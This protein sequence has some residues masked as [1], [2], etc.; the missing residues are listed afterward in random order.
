MPGV[1]L[2]SSQGLAPQNDNDKFINITLL[3]IKR[4]W[5]GVLIILIY[6]DLWKHN[7][8]DTLDINKTS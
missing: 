7:V 3:T 2:G 6:I 1:V 8:L 5:L 4:F